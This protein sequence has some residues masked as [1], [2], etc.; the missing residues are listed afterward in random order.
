MDLLLE[1][2]SGSSSA[3][4][5]TFLPQQRNFGNIVGVLDQNVVK[6]QSEARIK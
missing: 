5:A 4:T 2:E 6:N 1:W 3:I